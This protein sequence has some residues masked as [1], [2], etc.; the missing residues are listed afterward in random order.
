MKI[1]FFD[2]TKQYIALSTTC[3]QYKMLLNN[4]L[5]KQ[6]P[7]VVTNSATRVLLLP[8]PIAIMQISFYTRLAQK[9]SKIQNY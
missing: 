7:N 4:A 9:Y 8:K 3:K 1:N 2:L 6:V 5:T